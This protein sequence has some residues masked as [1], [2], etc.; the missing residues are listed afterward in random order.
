MRKFSP[1][2]VNVTIGIIYLIIAA[3]GTVFFMYLESEEE[4]QQCLAYKQDFDF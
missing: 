2:A 3:G 1:F 4:D